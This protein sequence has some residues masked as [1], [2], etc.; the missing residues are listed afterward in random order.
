MFSQGRYI[1]TTKQIEEDYFHRIL[2]YNKKGTC[3]CVEIVNGN[4]VLVSIGDKHRDKIKYTVECTSPFKRK[5]IL[6][7]RTYG[8][9]ISFSYVMDIFQAMKDITEKEV[10]FN[11]EDIKSGKVFRC[12]FSLVD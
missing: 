6:N 8:S 2:Y 12:K 9:L 11:L 4:D 5:K 3:V 1:S 7:K 10:I